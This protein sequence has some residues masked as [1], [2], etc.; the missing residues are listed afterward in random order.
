MTLASNALSYAVLTA[1][2]DGIV[3]A[4]SAEPGQVVAAG[5]PAV[6][7][8]RTAEKEALVA[9][10]EAKIQ[11]V[12]SGRPL[13][14]LWAHPGRVWDVQ[15]R[16]VSPSADPATRTFAAR[17]TIQSDK[18]GVDIGMTG[19]VAVAAAS[20]RKI[21]RLPLGALFNAGDGPAVWV[22]DRDAGTLSRRGVAVA[23][24]DAASV[25]IADGLRDGEWVVAMGVHKLDAGQRVRVVAAPNS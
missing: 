1:D 17:Y 8:A 15:L 2:A 6:R 21:A 4:V 18:A 24:Y 19:T 3:T 10:P 20:S 25:L 9:I 22:V 11:D 12:R 7:V 14:T 16:E 5:Q 13:L 23:G